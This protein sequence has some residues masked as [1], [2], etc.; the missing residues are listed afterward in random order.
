VGGIDDRARERMRPTS[1]GDNCHRRPRVRDDSGRGRGGFPTTALDGERN[2][3]E[4]GKVRARVTRLRLWWDDAFWVI[5]LTGLVAAVVADWIVD[6]ADEAFAD[7][8]AELASFSPSSAETLLASIGGGMVTFTGFVFSVVLLIIQFGSSSYSP[9][10]VAFF[11]RSRVTQTVLAIFVATSA[12]AFLALLSIGSAGRDSYVPFFGVLVSLLFLLA[13]LVAFLALIQNVAGRIRVDAVLSDLGRVARRAMLR[14]MPGAGGQV[15][16]LDVVPDF[17]DGGA[18]V[19]HQGETGQIVGIDV[20]LAER[21]AA[22]SGVE[23][24]FLVRVGDGIAPGTR[25]AVLAADSVV[26]RFDRCVIVHRERSLKYDPVYALRIITDVGLRA[27]SPAINDPTTAVRA[28]DE[29]EA[30]LRAAAPLPLGPIRI[31]AGA[32]SIVVRGATWSDFVD[33]GIWEVLEAG[34]SA[35]QVTRRL[36]ALLSDLLADLPAQRHEPLLRYRQRLHAAV[37]ESVNPRD[38]RPWLVSDNQGIGG[39]R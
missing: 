15:A 30:V 5:P 38:A 32:G 21:M 29:V 20:A 2:W 8:V 1:A 14:P 6:G 37:I 33:L 3:A 23:V 35:P 11:L 12:Y 34:L 19:R 31:R 17:K 7:S 27:L 4:R 16:V 26:E 36:S 39:E 28:L 22:R 24:V 25:V 13:S 10:T 18:V 9:R